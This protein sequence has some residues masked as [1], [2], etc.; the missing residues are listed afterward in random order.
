MKRWAV[1]LLLCSCALAALHG[2]AEAGEPF[3]RSKRERIEYPPRYKRG[4]M[5]QWYVYRDRDGHVHTRKV[6]PGYAEHFPPPAYLYYGYPH[7]G[8]DTGPGFNQF[9]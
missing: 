8:D 4:S 9:P 3:N 5:S 2:P 7:S 1:G 6:Y